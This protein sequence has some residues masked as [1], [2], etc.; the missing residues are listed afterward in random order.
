MC[1]S[2]ESREQNRRSGQTVVV[3]D[4]NHSDKLWDLSLAPYLGREAGQSNQ[5][6]I[7]GVALT[8]KHRETEFSLCVSGRGVGDRL[9]ITSYISPVYTLLI[10]GWGC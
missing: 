10:S 7:Q 2:N 8:N 6:H 5:T 9:P 4:K 1:K 3:G